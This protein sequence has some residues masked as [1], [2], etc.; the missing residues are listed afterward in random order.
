MF[1]AILG[2]VNCTRDTTL[3]Y[4]IRFLPLCYLLFLLK[5]DSFMRRKENLR[6]IINISFYKITGQWYGWYRKPSGA[7]PATRDDSNYY[8]VMWSNGNNIVGFR[9]RFGWV[10]IFHCFF[11]G[12]G[13]GR[14]S[15]SDIPKNEL[16]R[17]WQYNA[18][19][20]LNIDKS[21]LIVNPHSVILK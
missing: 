14:I 20:L 19:G 16:K 18:R 17:K 10:G 9:T 1:I 8:K 7:W 5:L 21:S 12:A 3:S 13:R 15:T 11:E 2:I 6:Y 4:N